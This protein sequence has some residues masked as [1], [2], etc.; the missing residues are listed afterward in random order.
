MCKKWLDSEPCTNFKCHNNLFWED[1]KLNREKIQMTDKAFEIGNCCCLIVHPWSPEEI[2]E[3]WGLTTEAV[4]RSEGEALKKLQMKIRI[5][6]GRKNDI[7][8]D[9]FPSSLRLQI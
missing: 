1:L 8:Y 2:S 9:R 7:A 4:R 3:A 5:N 6:S